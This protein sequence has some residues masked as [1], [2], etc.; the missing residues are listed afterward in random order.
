M[1]KNADL[2][3]VLK[4]HGEKNV[5]LIFVLKTMKKKCRSDFCFENMELL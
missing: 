2:I 4:N 5:D 3:L 1:E